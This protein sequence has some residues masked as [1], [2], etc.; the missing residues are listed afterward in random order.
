MISSNYTCTGR[1][2]GYIW[3][4]FEGM[5][6]DGEINEKIGAQKQRRFYRVRFKTKRG[7]ERSEIVSSNA[8]SINIFPFTLTIR[9]DPPMMS[10][11]NILTPC[12][13]VIRIILRKI[14]NAF[15]LSGVKFQSNFLSF[16]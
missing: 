14:S 8:N 7:G 11:T 16:I 3:D 13:F 9:I 4:M 15:L 5:I 6:L 1:V 2:G 12:I 10:H